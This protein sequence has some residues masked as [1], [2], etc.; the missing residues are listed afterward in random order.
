MLHKKLTNIDL[1][2]FCIFGWVCEN[3]D[4]MGGIE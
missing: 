2:S 1:V 3:K 4:M